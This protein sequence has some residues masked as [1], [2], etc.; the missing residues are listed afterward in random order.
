MRAAIIQEIN[1]S[2]KHKLY[3]VCL[4]IDV[5]FVMQKVADDTIKRQKTLRTLVHS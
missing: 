5:K 3:D 2:F 1:A 4:Q